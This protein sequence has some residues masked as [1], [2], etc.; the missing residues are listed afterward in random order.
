MQPVHGTLDD[1]GLL[2]GFVDLTVTEVADMMRGASNP[3]GNK[4]PISAQYE[5]SRLTGLSIFDSSS[6]CKCLAAVQMLGGFV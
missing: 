1:S 6:L 2:S 5:N 4:T 3:S